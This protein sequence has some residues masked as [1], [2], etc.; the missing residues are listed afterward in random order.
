MD[1]AIIEVTDL[2]KYFA[3][4][5]SFMP[6][7]L[8]SQETYIKAVDGVNFKIKEGEIYGLVGESGC[9]KTTA[10]RAVL[11]LIEPTSGRIFYKGEDF[12]AIPKNKLKEHRR[13]MQI[14][15]QDPFDSLNPRMTIFDL[16]SEPLIIHEIGRNE[17]E[18]IEMV[19]KTLESVQIVPPQD[20]IFRYPHELSGG[21]RQRIAIA[22]ALILNPKFIV[23]DEPVSMLDV[24]IRTE[25][26]NLMLDLKTEFGLTYLFITHDL[27]ISKYM[28]NDIAVMYLGKIVERGPVEKVI[29]DPEHPYTQALVTAVPVPETRVESKE[30]PIKGEPPTPMNLPPGCI[31]NPR[32]PYAFDK[33]F[34]IEPELF[35][36]SEEHSAACFLIEKK[37]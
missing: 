4:R 12:T 19:S 5:K 11:R 27:A 28:S 31:F 16:I 15:F 1:E 17:A 3:L 32:C 18:R 14:I 22:R 7:L 33:C 34:K 29:D 36:V 8:S 2:K 21:Q 10:G 25:V 23:A 30:I 20:F 9:G 6:G 26:L 13:E 24:S 37:R 35:P